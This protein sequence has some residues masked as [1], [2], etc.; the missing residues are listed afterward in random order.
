MN[1]SGFKKRMS[2]CPPKLRVR[3]RSNMSQSSAGDPLSNP[4][5]I[6]KDENIAAKQNLNKR[7][8]YIPDLKKR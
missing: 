3:D 4:R 7:M 8:S 5:I 1:D 2:Y 6:L